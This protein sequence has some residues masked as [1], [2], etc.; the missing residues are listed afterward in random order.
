MC[1]EFDGEEGFDFIATHKVSRKRELLIKL[2]RDIF[3]ESGGIV[4][5]K[6]N[7]NYLVDHD[8]ST[9]RADVGQNAYF[10]EGSYS[11]LFILRNHTSPAVFVSAYDTWLA[12][13]KP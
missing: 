13:R 12:C 1:R 5:T 11:A 9:A 4:H 6:L 3:G 7:M 2:F 8:L 10:P